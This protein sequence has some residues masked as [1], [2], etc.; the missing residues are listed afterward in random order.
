MSKA[1][2]TLAEYIHEKRLIY[3]DIAAIVGCSPQYIG[4]IAKG[5]RTPSFIVAVR[6]ERATL[7]EVSRE[8]W[9]PRG[10][11]YVNLE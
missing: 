9:Y 6:I 2:K 3:P 11:D 4:M 5:L 10:D 8:N 7:G 1:L